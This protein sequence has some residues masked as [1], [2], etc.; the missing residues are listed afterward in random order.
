M[1]YFEL[2]LWY[3][4]I[5]RYR[6]FN[7]MLLNYYQKKGQAMTRRLTEAEAERM[8]EAEADRIA[9]RQPQ[10]T[11]NLGARFSRLEAEMI[12]GTAKVIGMPVSRLIR[13]AAMRTVVDPAMARALL[14][15]ARKEQSLRIDSLKPEKKKK[16][17]TLYKQQDF[18]GFKK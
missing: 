7:K 1:D 15:A 5:F 18:E 3:A 2:S 13:M 9:N 16:V 8:T 4:D 11:V 6:H 10:R 17:R 12:Q 14:I